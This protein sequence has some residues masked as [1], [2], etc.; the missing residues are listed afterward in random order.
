MIHLS[1]NPDGIREEI[2]MAKFKTQIVDLVNRIV[3]TVFGNGLKIV[4]PLDSIPKELHTQL[5][6]HGLKQKIGDAT[7]A[8]SRESDYA[9]AFRAAQGVADNLYQ[10]VWAARNSNGITDLV[11]AISELKNLTIEEAQEIID[12]LD[13]EQVKIVA[14][15]PAVKARILK[16]KSE[17]AA[18]IAARSE[19]DD[20]GI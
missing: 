19:D 17:R 2:G 6:L 4:V 20:L 18:A 15:K 13:D 10:G 8:F 9:G 1:D 3:T 12:S 14:N 16:I 5:A 7:S 11:L